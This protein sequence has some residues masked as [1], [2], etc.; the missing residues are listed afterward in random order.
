MKKIYF[1]TAVFFFILFSGYSNKPSGSASMTISA[2]IKSSQ[3]SVYSK[4]I[5]AKIFIKP[6]KI[7]EF[8]ELFKGMIENTLKEP[9]C[10][11]YQLYQDPYDPTKFLVFESYRNQAAIDSHFAAGYFKD[12]GKRIGDLISHPSEIRIIDVAREVD[13]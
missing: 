2:D 7:A 4:I 3:D 10:T 13:Q 11:G 8:T 6:D 1:L 12:F 5:A 9:G